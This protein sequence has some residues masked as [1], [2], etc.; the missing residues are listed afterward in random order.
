[1]DAHPSAK[2]TVGGSVIIVHPFS[3]IT[4]CGQWLYTMAASELVTLGS[5]VAL[6]DE[7]WR[8]RGMLKCDLSSA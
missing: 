1:M 2:V 5:V 6:G 4:F 3:F 8:R 7:E